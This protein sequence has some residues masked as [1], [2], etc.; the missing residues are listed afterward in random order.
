M[1]THEAQAQ[2]QIFPFLSLP[3]E[4]RNKI[5]R[6]L[7][8]TFEPAPTSFQ[9]AS[10]N[11]ATLQNATHR[12][13]HTV[14]TTIL[15]TC[16]QVHREAYDVMTKTNKFV[17]ISTANIRIKPILNSFGVPV[18]TPDPRRAN[19]FQ[20]YI[21]SISM[22]K[23]V[24]ADEGR[25]EER[26]VPPPSSMML[27][28]RDMDRVC[29]ALMEGD[30]H[31]PGFSKGLVMSLTVGY[32]SAQLPRYKASLSAYLD[33]EHNQKEILLPFRTE[34]RGLKAVQVKGSVSRSLALAVQ[35]DI[36]RDK[37]SEPQEVTKIFKAAKEKGARLFQ[38]KNLDEACLEWQDATLEIECMHDGASWEGLIRAGGPEF[39]SE[40][41]EIYFQMKLNIA[42]IQLK[43]LQTGIPGAA[44][45]LAE[46]ALNCA[47]T[48]LVKFNEDGNTWRPTHLQKAKWNHRRALLLR[49]EGLVDRINTAVTFVNTALAF[50]PGDAV[51]LA[52]KQA[53]MAWRQ[54]TLV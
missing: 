15:R 14:S 17:R 44:L 19:A 37:W 29:K 28:W 43:K 13:H 6:I 48:F 52:E 39:V 25:Y 1:A 45:L 7:L 21:L 20:G 51:I 3:A 46:D 32:M 38:E 53:I 47:A 31:M 12:A 42:H 23:K 26:S 11:F 18:V 36:A 24:A 10:L 4:I 16:A 49:L 40:I 27:L 30:A 2:A 50:A 5:Y 22:V 41:A 8:C 34:L 9:V 35:E 33:L 54:S